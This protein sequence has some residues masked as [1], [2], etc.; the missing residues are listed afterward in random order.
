MGEG[1]WC[2][3]NRENCF[4]W[5]L[6][7]NPFNSLMPRRGPSK[8]CT[9]G[10]VDISISWG[11]TQWAKCRSPEKPPPC[12]QWLPATCSLQRPAPTG[13]ITWASF[14]SCGRNL[15]EICWE[16]HH[17][18]IKVIETYW[19]WLLFLGSR[20]METCQL[21]GTPGSVVAPLPSPSSPV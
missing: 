7:S 9:P 18:G 10:P 19:D 6:H 2:S 5:S 8:H 16:E 17:F 1:K 12:A 21:Q 15:I 20:N 4:Q 14:S 3:R 13:S 11:R